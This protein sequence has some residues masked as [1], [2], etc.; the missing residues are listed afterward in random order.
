MKIITRVISLC[1]WSFL[2]VACDKA[3][4][5]HPQEYYKQHPKE[6]AE[7]LKKC[8]GNSDLI[9]SDQNCQNAADAEFRSGSFKKNEPKSW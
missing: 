8:Q 6:R 3:V 7:V 2:L 4:T 1:L 5:V 9:S